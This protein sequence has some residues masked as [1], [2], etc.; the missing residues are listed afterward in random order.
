MNTGRAYCFF[1]SSE[2]FSKRKFSRANNRLQ[3][4]LKGMKADPDILVPI[5]Q[6]LRISLHRLGELVPKLSLLD[7]N[8][9]KT[10]LTLIAEEWQ[11]K[12]ADYLIKAIQ[13]AST[14]RKVADDLAYVFNLLYGCTEIP[15]VNDKGI[16][17]A[18]VYFRNENG[19]YVSKLQVE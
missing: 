8:G 11:K 15:Y 13:P 10:P 5:P 18:D 4:A 16:P 2:E 3:R 12:G 17:V 7:C 19:I 6:N 1:K 9:K 14:N